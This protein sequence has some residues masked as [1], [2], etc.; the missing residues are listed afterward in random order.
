MANLVY[1][2]EI[3]DPSEVPE[4][5]VL[6]LSSPGFIIK[7]GQEY[8]VSLAVI[9]YD[10]EH[11]TTPQ[12]H[13]GVDQVI[14]AFNDQVSEGHTLVAVPDDA[15]FMLPGGRHGQSTDPQPS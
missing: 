5:G 6:A 12:E 8:W 2:K 3:S 7:A 14:E 11:A 4:G 15:P 1:V 10:H 13:E 9:G